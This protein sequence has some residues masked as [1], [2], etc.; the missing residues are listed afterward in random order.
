MLAAVSRHCERGRV[1]GEARRRRMREKGGLIGAGVEKLRVGSSSEADDKQ[2]TNTSRVGSSS[3]AN[4]KQATNTSLRPFLPLLRLILSIVLSIFLPTSHCSTVPS[5]T[6]SSSSFSFSPPHRAWQCAFCCPPPPRGCPA[7][8][9]SLP[10][11]RSPH[12]PR[13]GAAWSCCRPTLCA[14]TTWRERLRYK[15]GGG[16]GKTRR[17]CVKAWGEAREGGCGR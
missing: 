12:G 14:P 16:V 10:A 3:K 15:E 7:S 8:S 5:S 6:P 17:K 9:A 11:P 2:A 13:R 4:D 1:F